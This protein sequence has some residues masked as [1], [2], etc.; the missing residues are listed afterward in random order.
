MV[1]GVAWLVAASGLLRADEAQAQL[2]ELD[3]AVMVRAAAD[4]KIYGQD[5]ID[6]LVW[7]GS[8]HF[9]A[10]DSRT[11]LLAAVAKVL[12]LSDAEVRHCP[13]LQ[14]ALV[15]NRVWTVFDSVK[16]RQPN[17]GDL[18]LLAK[19]VAKLALDAAE[20]KSLADPLVQAARSGSW[21]A[22]P[23]ERGGA[24]AFLPRGLAD[25]A[26]PWVDLLRHDGELTAKRHT[27]EF[28]GRTWFLVRAY[29][30]EGRAALEKYFQQIAADPKPWTD[31]GRLNRSLPILPKNAMF[32][33]ERRLAVIDREGR[34][35]ATPVTLSVQIRR[36]RVTDRTEFERLIATSA[37][38]KITQ[39]RMQNFSEFRLTTA[40]AAAGQA[41]TLRAVGA[42]ERS[43]LFFS[44]FDI[45]QID[46]TI[47]GSNP[48]VVSDFK[49]GPQDLPL[50]SCFMCH[51]QPGLESLNTLAFS[52]R[53]APLA[54]L[55]PA[56]SNQEIAA[57]NRWKTQQAD[58]QALR[59]LWPH[60]I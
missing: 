16:L 2:A 20:I 36:H 44:T 37:E 29:F 11:R 39:Q 59:A 51:V 45:D 43:F 27:T 42:E 17:S 13:P 40:A 35:Q 31:D 23:N 9:L 48:R 52:D 33:L 60:G 28:G 6:P 10:G 47:G 22:E 21:P 46:G 55:A 57:T 25:E 15:Q 4:G 41:A 38:L 18:P 32:A 7:P 58:W 34:W 26:G 8:A 50:R 5:E 24:D 3:R 53:S 54:L 12:S 14:R 19:A 56:A 49:S 1:L 30:P